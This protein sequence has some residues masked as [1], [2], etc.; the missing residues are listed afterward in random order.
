MR[1]LAVFTAFVERDLRKDL[2]SLPGVFAELFLQPLLF[3]FVFAFVLPAVGGIDRSYLSV[4]VPGLTVMT[5]MTSAVTGVCLP[6]L[7]ELHYTR[8]LEDRLAA[9]VPAALVAA[10]KMTRAVIR[11]CL[12]ALCFL[13][14][15]WLLVGRSPLDYGAGVFG[16][17]FLAAVVGSGVGMVL[18]GFVDVKNIDAMAAASVSIVGFTGCAQYTW[19]SLH[20]LPLFQWATLLNPLTY[21]SE[22]ARAGAV[23]ALHPALCSGVLV[24]VAAATWVLGMKRFGRIVS[25]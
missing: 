11:S 24:I 25:A 10:A 23:S 2:A 15:A 9:P 6:V 16:A 17:A 12:G 5:A 4:L 19:A 20:A 14:V 18:A 21:A 7:I 13:L 3:L 8:E 1:R 22:L